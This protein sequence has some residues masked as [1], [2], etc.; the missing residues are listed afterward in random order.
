MPRI[1]TDYSKA[2]IYKIVCND[3]KIKEVYYGSTTNFKARKYNHK[4]TCHNEN[5]KDYNN[6]KYQFIRCN[7]GWN[8]WNMVLVKEFSCKNKLE[9]EREERLCMEQDE[10]RLNCILPARTDDELKEYYKQHYID[11]IETIRE[12]QKQYYIKNVDKIREQ[13]KQKYLKNKN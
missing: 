10:N 8:N 6:P 1:A 3:I 7:G 9:L 13:Q 11:N 12:R 2:L 4:S 5:H